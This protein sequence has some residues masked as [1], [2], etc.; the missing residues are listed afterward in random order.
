M[1]PKWQKKIISFIRKL[2]PH[3]MPHRK[4]GEMN[5]MILK[6]IFGVWVV[7]YMKW[8]TNNHHLGHKIW[9]AYLR[10]FKKEFMIKLILNIILIS[11][12]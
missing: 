5:H 8:R 12:I 4:F 11:K 3:I 1:Y 7:L 2:E 9:K 10:K 6:V